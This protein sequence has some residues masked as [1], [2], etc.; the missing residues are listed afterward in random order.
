MHETSPFLRYFVSANS[1]DGFVCYYDAVFSSLRRRYIIKGGPGTG[2][3]HLMWDI[4]NEAANRNIKTELFFCSSDPDSLDGILLTDVQIAVLD[5]T[6]PH[7]MEPLYPGVSDEII[8]LGEFWNEENLAA[9]TKEIQAIITEKARK[10]VQVSHFLS[11]AEKVN[12]VCRRIVEGALYREKMQRAVGRQ[13]SDLGYGSQCRQ[14]I[15]LESAIS[16]KGYITLDTYEHLARR[17]VYVRDRFGSGTFY[18]KELIRA[19]KQKNQRYQV[20]FCPLNPAFPDA[21]YVPAADTAYLC[22]SDIPS[23][24]E[25]VNMDRFLDLDII[26]ANRAKLRF[27]RQC[28]QSLTDGALSELADI[29]TLHRQLEDCYITAMDFRRK[30][31]FT[32]KLL[33]KIF[34]HIPQ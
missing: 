7:C 11:A 29:G 5:G 1:G 17:T 9:H 6:S 4:A 8:N 21:L 10:Y 2:K 16:T 31:E 28:T 14:D 20:S 24:A 27:G 33:H 30:E 12:T 34:S 18:L 15:R 22:R 19:L 32:K 23:G 25:C 3:S 26:R 13:L